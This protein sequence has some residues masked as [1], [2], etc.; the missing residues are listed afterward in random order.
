[1]NVYPLLFEPNLHPVVWGGLLIPEWKKLLPPDE[2]IG[3]SWEVSTVPTSV[4]RIANGSLRGRD[5][6]WAIAE[7]PEQILGRHVAQEAGGQLPLLVKLIDARR[8]LSIQ[9]HPDDEMAW[10]I[11]RKRGKSEMWYVIDAQPGAFLYAGFA[12]PLSQ[13]D[14]EGTPCS[15][16]EAVAAYRRHVAAGTIT[17]VLARHEVR[18]GDV[19]YLPA[20]RIHAIGSGILLAEVQQSSDVTYRIYDYDRPGI[21]GRPRELHTDLAAEALDYRVYDHYRADYTYRRGEANVVMRSRYFTV[22]VL[23]VEQS[24]HCD[25]RSHDSFVIVMCL[26]GECMVRICATGQAVMLHEGFSTLIPAST[27]DY[28]LVCCNPSGHSQVLDTFVEP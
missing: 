20:G 10:R 23:D 25:M 5:L 6:T 28:E 9:V 21:D 19:F 2:P 15:R 27:A 17:E 1:M 11:H 4:S 26:H 3:E 12:S 7:A 13:A 8:N 18:A 16:E 22:R 24:M 14:A